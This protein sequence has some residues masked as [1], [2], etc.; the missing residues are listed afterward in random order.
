MPLLNPEIG[1]PTLTKNA[2]T[3]L[4]V[5]GLTVPILE[6]AKPIAYCKYFNGTSVLTLPIY[7]INDVKYPL[8]RIETSKGL[9][10]F[11]LV[12]LT[13]SEASSVRISTQ[14]GIFSIKK[15]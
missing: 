10:C 4:V 15:I 13:N 2:N 3:P 6:K 11:D 9:G 14:Y 12:S 7:K 1:Y 5:D 8:I